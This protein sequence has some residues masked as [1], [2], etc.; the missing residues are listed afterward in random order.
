MDGSLSGKRGN[1]GLSFPILHSSLDRYDNI[2]LE[3]SHVRLV[4]QIDTR[5][6]ESSFM[7]AVPEALLISAYSPAV[8]GTEPTLCAGNGSRL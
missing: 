6:I 2:D 1:A 8:V 7:L 5:F 4:Q 3:S